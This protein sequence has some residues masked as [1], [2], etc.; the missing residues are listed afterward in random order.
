MQQLNKK[1]YNF[2]IPRYLQQST[3]TV[4]PTFLF[5]DFSDIRSQ[6]R[7]REKE[8][9]SSESKSSDDD[10][11]TFFFARVWFFHVNAHPNPWS[12]Q[13]VRIS[14]SLVTKGFKTIITSGRFRAYLI[15]GSNSKQ[16]YEYLL[17]RKLLKER[18]FMLHKRSYFANATR[19]DRYLYVIGG[20]GD[21]NLTKL[22]EFT[23]A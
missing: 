21:S 15:G 6:M 16:C 7:N 19:S 18:Q 2:I 9:H 11:G 10:K 4:R 1:A 23:Y 22:T 13:Q 5:V 20:R 12:S 8:K 3:L 17:P 14:P